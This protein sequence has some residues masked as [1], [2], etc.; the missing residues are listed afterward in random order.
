MQEHEQDLCAYLR[1]VLGFVQVV[2]WSMFG[3]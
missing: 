3:D 2:A 1:A